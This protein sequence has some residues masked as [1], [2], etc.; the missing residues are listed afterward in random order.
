MRNSDYF[1]RKTHDLL[2]GS[3][4][5]WTLCQQKIYSILL[6]AE[7]RCAQNPLDPFPR[8]FPVEGK[9]PTCYRLA[10]KKILRNW[11][12]GVWPL[13]FISVV[14]FLWLRS[15]VSTDVWLVS[16]FDRGIELRSCVTGATPAGG[17]VAAVDVIDDVT[18]GLASSTLSSPFCKFARATWAFTAWCLSVIKCSWSSSAKHYFNDL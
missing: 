18:S 8:S 7:R 16:A 2:Q 13:P 11:C 17:V 12:K 5:I 6:L 14:C 4:I 3:Y 1:N 15:A 9:S 10:T